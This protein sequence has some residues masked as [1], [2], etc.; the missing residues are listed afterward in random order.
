MALMFVHVVLLGIA[1]AVAPLPVIVAIALVETRRP[2][3][4]S[5]AYLVGGLLV[6]LVLAVAGAAVMEKIGEDLG[7]RHRVSNTAYGL[8]TAIGILFLL[9][10]VVTWRSKRPISIPPRVE[11][12]LDSIGVYRAF[13]LG[14]VICSPGLKNIALMVAALA[15]IGAQD[16]TIPQGI[17]AMGLFLLIALAP[18]AAPVLTYLALP[19][20]RA[21]ALTAIWKAWIDDHARAIIVVVSTAIGVVLLQD[22]LAGLLG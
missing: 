22:G 1:A 8:V 17:V 2:V 15:T 4:D 14:L 21:K 9:I 18:P 11:R 12:M 13:A 20:D 3:A 6:Y 16:V 19:D 7:L 10:A 5:I